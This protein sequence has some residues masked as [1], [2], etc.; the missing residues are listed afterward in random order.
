MKRL[1]PSVGLA[2]ALLATP[3]AAAVISQTLAF[4]S[5]GAS[6]YTG[7]S[8][9][10]VGML[11]DGVDSGLFTDTSH[12]LEQR[13]YQVEIA[14]DAFSYVIPIRT[15]GLAEDA[16]FELLLN[17]V[18]IDDFTVRA[19]PGDAAST[20]TGSGRILPGQTFPGHTYD[21]QILRIQLKRDIS[22]GAGGVTFGVGGTAT[23][24]A[25]AVPEPATWAMMIAGFGLAGAA[26]RRRRSVSELPTAA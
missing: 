26:I 4:P 11:D 14:K 8:P 21:G 1:I 19:A 20:I 25:S 17:G 7:T 12:W 2:L 6:F 13:F 22:P 23:F 24:L 10:D 3:A 5:H 9:D 16:F 15:L 18:V